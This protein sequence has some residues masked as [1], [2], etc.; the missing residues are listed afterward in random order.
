MV[1][2]HKGALVQER[3]RIIDVALPNIDAADDD[4]RF[5]VPRKTC[6]FLE[7]VAGGCQEAGFKEQVLWGYPVRASSGKQI[8]SAPRLP[9]DGQSR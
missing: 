4:N 6:Q 2:I 5:Q 7:G 3:R 1:D 9:L 8:R